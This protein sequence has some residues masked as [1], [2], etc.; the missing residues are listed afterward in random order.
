MIRKRRVPREERPR[1][2]RLPLPLW[3]RVLVLSVGWF[4]IV[5]GLVGLALPI[6]QGGLLLAIGL[7]LLSVGSQTVHLWMRKFFGRFP[8]LWKR[9]EKLRRKIHNFLHRPAPEQ[10]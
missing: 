9:M 2:Q 7:A 1:F 5:L 10:E 8:G 6:L 3:L 4:C